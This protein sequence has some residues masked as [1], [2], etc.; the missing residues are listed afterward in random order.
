MLEPKRDLKM[1]HVFAVTLKPEMPG[2]DDARM[3]R[4]NRHFMD[5]F[6]F[7]SEEICHATRANRL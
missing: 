5:L 1:K 3:D 7:N 6:A 4:P 2:L